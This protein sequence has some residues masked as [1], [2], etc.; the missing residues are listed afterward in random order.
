MNRVQVLPQVMAD[1]AVRI[2][3]GAKEYGEQLTTENGRDALQD[4]YEEA[5]DLCMYLKQALI[6]RTGGAGMSHQERCELLNS[7]RN[8]P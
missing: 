8:D 4:A 3:K 2:A 1:M 5:L 6:E 7:L